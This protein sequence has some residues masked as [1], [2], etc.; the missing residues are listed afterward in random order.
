MTSV[1]ETLKNLRKKRVTN[2]FT[3]KKKLV[4]GVKPS[5]S[6]E[7]AYRKDLMPILNKAQ[8]ELE[9]SVY[10]LI[11]SYTK[12][13]FTDTTQKE[14]FDQINAISKSISIPLENYATKIAGLFTNN[15]NKENKKKL[16]DNFKKSF[17]VNLQGLLKDESIEKPINDAIIEN[18]DLI[19]TIPKEYLERV[20]DALK[21]GLTEGKTAADIRKFLRHD[22]FDISERRV[23]FIARDQTSKLNGDLTRVR[24]LEV[25]GEEYVWMGRNDN[26]ERET[27]KENNNKKFKWNAPP[28]TGHPGAD[29][30]CRCWAKLIITF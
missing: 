6:I 9:L 20:K 24:A 11:D 27:H 18:V 8:K 25:G 23:R 21:Q 13:F 14:I 30:G 16:Y 5:L 2:D 10:P 17:G 19:K 12:K 4:S 28:K 22:A 1:S 3:S 26:L 7:V 15:V 29:F